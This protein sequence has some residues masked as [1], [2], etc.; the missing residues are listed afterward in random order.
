VEQARAAETANA[1]TVATR[2]QRAGSILTPKDEVQLERALG[3][4]CGLSFVSE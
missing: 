4:S 1:V 2:L 3:R